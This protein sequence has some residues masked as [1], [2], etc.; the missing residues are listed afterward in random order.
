[1][2]VKKLESEG[3]SSYNLEGH[4]CASL[5][6]FMNRV[7]GSRGSHWGRACHLGHVVA[8]VAV[9]SIIARILSAGILVLVQG[10]I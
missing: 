1:M 6:I 5:L 7:G 3:E 9:D 4:T 10:L 2:A 8:S